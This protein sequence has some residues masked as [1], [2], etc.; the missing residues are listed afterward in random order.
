MVASNSRGGP[1]PAMPT[2]IIPFL[3]ARK[4]SQVK[5]RPSSAKLRSRPGN[6]RVQCAGRLRVRSGSNQNSLASLEKAPG[7]E[8][9][10]EH[11][12]AIRSLR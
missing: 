12:A 6:L 4:E 9:L 11:S 7:G 2:P 3:L 8:Y 1:V 5:P 10:H